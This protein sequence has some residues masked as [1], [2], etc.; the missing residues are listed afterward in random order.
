MPRSSHA[1]PMSTHT[2]TPSPQWPSRIDRI[3]GLLL[4][5]TSAA[6]AVVATGA[7]VLGGSLA[8][9]LNGGWE[10]LVWEITLV[11][12]IPLAALGLLAITALVQ[13]RR[14]PALGRTMAGAIGVLEVGVTLSRA[15]ESGGAL[16]VTLSG[17]LLIMS[18]AAAWALE[19]VR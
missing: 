8:S 3:T 7:V 11:V 9:L 6:A 4:T 12:A 5:L 13:L 16:A 15:T 14:R 17:V 18:A 2:V 19:P 10:T 1:G